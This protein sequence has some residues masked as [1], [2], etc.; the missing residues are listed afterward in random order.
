VG[1]NNT[2]RYPLMNPVIIPELP[3]KDDPATPT[4]E[5]FAKTAVI[6]SII[7]LAVVGVGLLVNFKKRKQRVD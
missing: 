2:D 6:A 1:K 5:P 3:E 4:G 7:L